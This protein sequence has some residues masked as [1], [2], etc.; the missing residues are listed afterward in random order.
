MS[1]HVFFLSKIHKNVNEPT[2]TEAK[3]ILKVFEIAK[4][5]FKLIQFFFNTS[6]QNKDI[7]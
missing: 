3:E 4:S 2:T 6:S 7:F 5:Q 1:Y